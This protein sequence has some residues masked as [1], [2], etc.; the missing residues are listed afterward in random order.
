MFYLEKYLHPV[1]MQW[2]MEPIF[3]WLLPQLYLYI[4][5]VA[6]NC[7]CVKLVALTSEH[8]LNYLIRASCLSNSTLHIFRLLF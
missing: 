8:L 4:V 2:F 1:Q 6:V 5:P 3:T 7:V